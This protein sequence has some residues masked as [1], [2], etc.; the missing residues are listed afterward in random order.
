[1]TYIEKDEGN[2]MT[3]AIKAKDMNARTVKSEIIT[4]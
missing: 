3:Q 2:T 1:M 4:F